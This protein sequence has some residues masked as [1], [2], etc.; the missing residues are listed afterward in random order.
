MRVSAP[1]VSA[2]S[3][4]AGDV[5]IERARRAPVTVTFLT[6]NVGSI[7][8]DHSGDGSITFNTVTTNSGSIELTATGGGLA[9]AGAVSAGGTGSVLLRT[10]LA[11]DVTLTGTTTA[12]GDSIVVRS[13]SAINGAGRLTA[14][15]VDLDAAAGIGNVTGLTVSAPTVSADSTGNSGIV[16]ASNLAAPVAASHLADRRRGPGSI[17]AS[18]QTGGGAGD[19]LHRAR[20]RT[21]AV[22]LT[23][24]TGRLDP[25]GRCPPGTP[26]TLNVNTGRREHRAGGPG[27]RGRSP[28]AIPALRRLRSP[29]IASSPPP[30][31]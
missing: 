25:E 20:P 30:P 16:I 14:G 23:S 15:R 2:A 11:G 29:A 4:N 21:A 31:P 13:A 10:L 24:D 6:A 22:T 8:L 27:R 17:T 7:D 5:I 28:P 12:N 1:T 26:A 18:S 9:V 3:T 19:L